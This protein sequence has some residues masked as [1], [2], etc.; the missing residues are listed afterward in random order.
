MLGHKLGIG[1][2]PW[3][4]IKEAAMEDKVFFSKEEL[5]CE[6]KCVYEWVDCVETEDGS[7]ICK[8]R[9]RNCFD[10]CSF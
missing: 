7:S 6:E 8:T 4:S 9:E 1:F 3:R 10:E 2:D 5:R